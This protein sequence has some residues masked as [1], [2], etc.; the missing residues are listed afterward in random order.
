MNN[1]LENQSN[2]TKY[3]DLY[4]YAMIIY[5]VYAVV[6]FVFYDTIFAS[7]IL[8][9]AIPLGVA[10]ILLILCIY[11]PTIKISKFTLIWLPFW[12]ICLIHF[13]L[14]S[15]ARSFMIQFYVLAL[16]IILVQQDLLKFDTL[17]IVL[18]WFGIVFL[19]S[20][21]FEMIL[22]NQYTT[23]IKWFFNAE[24][25]EKALHFLDVGYITGLSYQ[26]SNAAW[27]LTCGGVATGCLL[28]KNSKKSKTNNIINSILILIFLIM[29]N[30]TGK[31]S[32]LLFAIATFLLVYFVASPKTKYLT[33][34][35]IIA[36]LCV[37]TVI[38]LI[39]L[40]P[41]IDEQTSLGRLINLFEADDIMSESSGRDV[42]YIKAWEYFLQN[43]IFG[44]GWGKFSQISGT[45]TDVHNIYLQ[46]LCET[47]A[48]GLVAFLIPVICQYIYTLRVLFSYKNK[49]NKY[50][51]LLYFSLFI[52]TF[53]L[54]YGLTGNP[55]MNM[56]VFII[57]ILTGVFAINCKGSVI[58]SE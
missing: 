25:A 32:F 34:F 54:L 42:L 58:K 48:V 20:C 29:I 7:Q 22:P 44:I 19:L 6:L 24:Y 14:F 2:K 53:F 52:Q 17:L 23:F 35:F 56:D 9:S 21:F 47:G 39:L 15:V 13:M 10:V 40:A 49:K 41:Y 5:T 12:L 57:F 43:P 16:F 27:Y 8:I 38:I 11:N 3:L 30:F 37:S 31:R 51:Y 50:L 45:E 33:R 55:I 46:L 26:T 18:K 1:I 4:K 36:I 28:I